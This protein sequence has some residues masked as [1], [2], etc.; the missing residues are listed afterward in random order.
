[1]VRTSTST[2]MVPHGSRW[3]GTGSTYQQEVVPVPV[4]A[5]WR[6]LF[7][8]YK[9]QPTAIINQ[10]FPP[11]S[12]DRK[13]ANMIPITASAAITFQQSAILIEGLQTLTKENEDIELPNAIGSCVNEFAE[14]QVKFVHAINKYMHDKNN[15]IIEDIASFASMYAIIDSCPRVLAMKD[16]HGRIPIHYAASCSKEYES[17]LAET[18]R[19][20]EV[21]GV[22]TRSSGGFAV[23]I[24]SQSVISTFHNKMLKC[25]TSS[26]IV[27]MMI[28]II[29][30]LIIIVIKYYFYHVHPRVM[31]IQE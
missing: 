14:A 15:Y 24:N 6:Q 20:Y 21:G 7:D 2:S 11:T 25:H 23:N 9:I 28:I 29:I 19:K 12:T 30:I 13:T 16:S 4:P 22:E 8:F 27:I 31:M 10:Y 26:D 18:M 1:M 17:L 5:G 3:Y